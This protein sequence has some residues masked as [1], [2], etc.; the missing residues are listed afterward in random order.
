MNAAAPRH[1]LDLWKLEAR[2]LRLILEDAKARKAARLGWP[3]GRPDADRPAEGRTLAMIFEKNSTRTRFSFDA[4]MRQLGGDVIISTATDMQLGRGETIEDTARVLSR[5]V[6]AVMLRSN[7][8]A[9]V[10]RL[11]GAASVPVINGLSDKSHPC[12]IIADLQAYEERCGPVEGKTL[13]W[14]GDGNNVCST[15]IHAAPLFGFEL[16]IASP[17]KYPPNDADLARAADLQGRILVT[18]DPHEAVD[19]ADCVITDTWVSMG[20]TD[21]DDRLAAL[22]PYQVDEALMARAKPGAVFMHDLPAH[23]GEE[24][25]GEVLDG[26]RSLAWDEAENRIHAQKSILAWCFGAL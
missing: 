5:M 14:V 1:F 23:R 3:K 24:V 7:S 21:R 22:A 13:A 20:D 4:A 19:G 17:A 12:Q 6:D 25:T 8:H 18:E 10:E 16:R 11:A 15:F 9:D 2:E 26:P